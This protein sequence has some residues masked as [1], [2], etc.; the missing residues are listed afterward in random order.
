MKVVSLGELGL[1][2]RIPRQAKNSPGLIQGIGDDAAVLSIPRDGR[3]LWT[4][5]CLIEG[6]H[7]SFLWTSAYTLGR[8]ALNVNLSDI[9]AMGGHPL[10]YTV[11]VGVPASWTVRQWDDLYRGL[12]EAAQEAGIVLAGGNTSRSHEVSIH[13]GL[14]GNALH[15]PVLRRGASVGD[16]IYLTGT[17][18][19]SSLGLKFLREGQ[20][21][22]KGKP[23]SD[24]IQRHLDPKARIAEGLVLSR[25]RIATSMIDVSDGLLQDLGHLCRAGDVGALIEAPSI[26]LS[27]AYTELAQGNLDWAMS[28]GEDYELLFTLHSK[29]EQRLRS[30]FRQLGT[31]LTRIGVVADRA[32]G[33][34]VMGEHGK[35]LR[36]QS[37][38]YDHFRG[39]QQRGSGLRTT[40]A[41]KKPS[42]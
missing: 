12:G 39:D 41:T 33:I 40:A 28:G 18:G 21:T 37:R 20:R 19:D 5:D 30:T 27:R 26:P 6:V 31:R 22:K 36:F 11:S 4:T 32:E 2:E 15:G 34:R 24:L 1:I 42:F 14:L 3:L 9:A 8:K 10:F 17:L 25:E 16:L 29:D 23:V 7:F 13:V 35:A 38:G